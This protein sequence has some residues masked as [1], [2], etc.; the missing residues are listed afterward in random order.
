MPDKAE[1]VRR[2][3][4]GVVASALEV[5][6][7]LGARTPAELHPGMLRRRIDHETLRSY[8]EIG[9]PLAPGQLLV[10]PPA[11]WRADW[12]AADPDRFGR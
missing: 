10:D 12:E 4:E 1:R 5:M 7:S 9:D 3:Q 2:Y 8:A 6:A 11:P